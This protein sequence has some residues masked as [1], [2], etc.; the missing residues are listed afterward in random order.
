[1]FKGMRHRAFVLLDREKAVQGEMK[2]FKIREKTKPALC[3][4]FTGMGCQWAAM[5]KQLAQFETIRTSL[6]S[7]TAALQQIEP[8]FDLL[9]LLNEQSGV[10][11]KSPL[12]SFVAIAA[13]QIALVDLLRQMNIEADYFVG[14]SIGELLCAYADGVLS[15]EETIACAYWRGKCIESV[16]LSKPEEG[17]MAAVACSWQEAT[18]WCAELANGQVWPACHNSTDSVTVSGLKKNVGSFLD[19]LQCRNQDIFARQVNS[20]GVAFHSPLLEDLRN[21]LWQKVTAVLGD[22][23]IRQRTSRWISTVYEKRQDDYQFTAAY[24]VDNL[25]LPV[26]FH[27]AL[28]RVPSSAVFLELGPHH[29]LQAIIKRTLMSADNGQGAAVKYLPSLSR[30]KDNAELL[31][32]MLGQLYTHGFNPRVELIYPRVQYPVPRG[33]ASLHSFIEWRHDRNFTVTQYPDFYNQTKLYESTRTIDLQVC[34]Y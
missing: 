29:L 28:V 1:M 22:K 12:N 11:L 7:C 30:Q 10:A 21:D 34:L 18:E 31:L 15:L 32:R 13:I 8:S 27:E 24:L 19:Q 4:I 33:T 17:A 23:P 20:S 16:Q 3:I 9:Q 26:R 25:I 5:G 6:N 2:S 14:H